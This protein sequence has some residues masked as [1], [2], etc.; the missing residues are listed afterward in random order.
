MINDLNKTLQI[1]HLGADPKQAS[2]NAPVTFSIATSEKWTDDEKNW[3]TRTDW[4]TIVV[5]G[6][7]RSYAKK[8]KK[9]DRIFVEG[10]LRNNNYEKEVGGEKVTMYSAEILASAIELVTAKDTE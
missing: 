1:G 9:G 10:K 4:H 5:F 3:Q 7:L 2:E 6:N 8:L